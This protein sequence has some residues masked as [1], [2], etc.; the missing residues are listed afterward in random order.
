MA[1]RN[2]TKIVG[3][4]YGLSSKE[5][6]PAMIKAIFENLNQTKPKN[7]FTIGINDD[8]SHTSLD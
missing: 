6:N 5:F 2:P 1:K 8:L 4:R 3:G 7:H